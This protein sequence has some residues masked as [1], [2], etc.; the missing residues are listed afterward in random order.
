MESRNFLKNDTEFICRF[1][2]AKV[3]QLGYTSRD[4]CNICLSSIHIDIN[5]GDRLNTCNGL[6]KPIGII[7]NSK[8]TFVIQYKCQKCGKLHNNKVAKD[9]NYDAI[10]ALS[11]KTYDDYLKKL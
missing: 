4:H 3:E 2:G 7:L 10:L 11:N 8:K 1:C 5:P 9:D 6:L